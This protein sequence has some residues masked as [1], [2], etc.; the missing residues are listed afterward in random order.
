MNTL[1]LEH[2]VH[3]GQ[4]VTGTMF[5][6]EKPL[7]CRS[8]R[9][10]QPDS[11]LQLSLLFPTWALKSPSRMTESPKGELSSTRER[12]Q[13]GRG[14]PHHCSAC[15]LKQQSDTSTRHKGAGMQPSHPL[16]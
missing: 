14:T 8:G 2:G 11:P 3:Y 16:R 1:M 13:E 5:N 6:N 15:R 4:S 9:P 7:G 10:F 12:R